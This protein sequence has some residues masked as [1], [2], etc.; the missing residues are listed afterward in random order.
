MH[1][2]SQLFEMNVEFSLSW[3]NI[4]PLVKKKMEM[5][6]LLGAIGIIQKLH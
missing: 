4:V 3:M 6:C 5:G 2:I 1:G